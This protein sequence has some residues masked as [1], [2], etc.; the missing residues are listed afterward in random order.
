MPQLLT[1]KPVILGAVTAFAVTLTTAGAGVAGEN[2]T[3]R[4]LGTAV[5]VD[6]TD[7][8]AGLYEDDGDFLNDGPT[9][10]PQLAGDE[11]S[12][13]TYINPAPRPRQFAG[14]FGSTADAVRGGSPDALLRHHRMGTYR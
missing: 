1:M 14:S 11:D 6:R 7:D 9:T 5:E 4:L 10:M 8:T 13:P 12:E 2:E 3:F